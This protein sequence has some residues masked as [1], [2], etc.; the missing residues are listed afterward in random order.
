MYNKH[1]VGKW[2]KRQ[3]LVLTQTAPHMGR[4]RI[5]VSLDYVEFL[6]SLRFLFTQ[7]AALL[8]ISRATLYCRLGEGG[9]NH[10]ST[11]TDISDADIDAEVLHIKTNHPNDGERMMTRHL[12][13]R[14]IIVPRSHFRVSIHRIDPENTALRQS[15][16]ITRRVYHVQCSTRR[17]KNF[18]ILTFCEFSQACNELCT[19]ETYHHDPQPLPVNL[20][21]IT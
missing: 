7:I 19:H 12:T 3:F 13:Q 6:H 20:I 21:T 11:Y 1:L 17:D 15:L 9:V 18:H 10:I 4:P 8:G 2:E 5:N 16:A 14:G